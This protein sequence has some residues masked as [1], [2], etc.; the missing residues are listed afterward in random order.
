[1][2]A[3]KDVLKLGQERKGAILLDVG[4]CFGNDVRKVAADGFPVE[5]IIASDLK[6]EF[7]DL[8]H[9][10]FRSSPESFPVQFIE[11]NALDPAFLSPFLG[12]V[13]PME[14]VNLSNIKTLNH[15][16]GQVSVIWAAALFH[17]FSEKDQRQLAHALGRLLSPESGSII[18][19]A[20][21][22][23]DNKGTMVDE[24]SEKSVRLFCHN[25]DSWKELWVGTSTDQTIRPVD[26]AGGLDAAVFSPDSVR[27]ESR[28]TSAKSRSSTLDGAWLFLWSITRI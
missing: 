2:P 18:F 6:R 1:M 9:L 10:L 21:I 8:G 12:A 13:E 22:A 20:H 26:E 23:S 19:G 5:Q 4:C 17:L 16:R 25:P 15:L 27:V 7:W 3:Y 28:L 11:G 14:K 24:S